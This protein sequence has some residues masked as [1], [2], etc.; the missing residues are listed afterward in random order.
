MVD[1]EDAVISQSN[2]GV[3]YLIDCTNMTVQNLNLTCN[4]HGVFSYGLT[5]SRIT[6]VHTMGN[7]CGVFLQR[8]SNNTVE[9][10]RSIDDWVGFDLQ[11]SDDNRVANNVAVSCEKGILLYEACT[12][13]IVANTLRGNLYGIRLYSSDSNAIFHN[14]LIDNLDQADALTSYGNAWD[15]NCEGN[16]WSGYNGTDTDNDGVGD[17]NLPWMEMDN[18]PLVSPFIPGDVNHDGK[19]DIFDVVKACASYMTIPSDLQW[20]PHA[21]IAEPYGMIDS[22][23]VIEIAINYAMKWTSP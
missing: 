9:N 12:N 3:L 14:N 2:I 22:F 15:N 13:R 16:Y 4:G 11:N 7:N 21:D 10:C 1:A 8:S 23:D 5:N 19:V 20:N 17:T 18:R 6:G